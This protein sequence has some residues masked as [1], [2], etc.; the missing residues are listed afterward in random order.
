MRS[1]DASEVAGFA[2]WGESGVLGGREQG[3]WMVSW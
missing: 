2:E 3:L 1:V